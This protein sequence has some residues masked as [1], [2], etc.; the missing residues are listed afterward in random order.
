MAV[1]VV[2][3]PVERTRSRTRRVR[4]PPI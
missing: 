2:A 3:P 4:S 1:L